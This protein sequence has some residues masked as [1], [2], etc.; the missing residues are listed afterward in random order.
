MLLFTGTFP[1]NC[2]FTANIPT[3]PALNAFMVANLFYV[4]GTMVD[5]AI[6][7]RAFVFVN[8]YT[9]ERHTGKKSVNGTQRANKSTK[10]AVNKHDTDNDHNKYKYFPWKKHANNTAQVRISCNQ[11]Q[12]CFQSSGRTYI[13]AECRNGI[14]FGICVIYRK[15]DDKNP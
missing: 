15:K 9:E 7:V 3:F 8:P 11:R 1:G 10:S 6:T 4:H 2:V 14:S 5:T 12:S 13:F